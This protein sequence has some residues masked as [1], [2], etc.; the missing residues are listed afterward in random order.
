MRT[1]VRRCARTNVPPTRASN[2]RIV[3]FVA[4]I[5]ALYPLCAWYAGYKARRRAAWTRY[6]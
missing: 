2:A 5:A 1:S 6:V 4:A 3:V